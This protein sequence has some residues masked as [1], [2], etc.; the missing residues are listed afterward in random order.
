MVKSIMYKQ[1]SKTQKSLW[2]E[3]LITDLRVYLQ[4]F[5]TLKQNRHSACFF[6]EDTWRHFSSCCVVLQ[7]WLYYNNPSNCVAAAIPF[8]NSAAFNMVNN[9]MI[10]H[11]LHANSSACHGLLAVTTWP[12]YKTQ[13]DYCLCSVVFCCCHLPRRKPASMLKL[14][15]LCYTRQISIDFSSGMVNLPTGHEMT[16]SKRS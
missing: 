11:Y 1:W 2:R 3:Q 10:P 5:V 13:R 4:L 16:A 12:T 14:V 9:G 8:S 7:A 15:L 6:R